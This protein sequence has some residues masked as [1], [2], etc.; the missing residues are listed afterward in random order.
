[1]GEEIFTSLTSKS[2]DFLIAELPFGLGF[3]WYWYFDVA[4]DVGDLL[5]K[6]VHIDGV[7]IPSTVWLV[8]ILTQ[9][10]HKLFMIRK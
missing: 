2:F 3:D 6:E 5:V 4:D 8:K 10:G 1:V 7:E 9:K